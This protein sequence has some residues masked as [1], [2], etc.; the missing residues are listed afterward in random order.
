MKDSGK[1][2]TCCTCQRRR[3]RAVMARHSEYREL[4]ACRSKNSCWDAFHREVDRSLSIRANA[5]PT[6]EQ[7]QR[8]RDLIAAFDALGLLPS[9]V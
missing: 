4:W 9:S 5:K 6:P 3:R 8:A 7:I 2:L 1:T